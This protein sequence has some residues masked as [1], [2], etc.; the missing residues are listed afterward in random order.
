[1]ADIL[2]ASPSGGDSFQRS[3]GSAGPVVGGTATA[4][5][6]RSSSCILYLLF[7]RGSPLQACIRL[8]G[9][10]EVKPDSPFSV[11]SNSAAVVREGEVREEN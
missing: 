1:M 6:R 4:F 7:R 10:D 8:L 3:K 5:G 11:T 9:R 2:A